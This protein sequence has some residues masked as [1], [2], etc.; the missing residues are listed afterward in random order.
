MQAHRSRDV[1]VSLICSSFGRFLGWNESNGLEGY[2]G[3]YYKLFVWRVAR[4]FIRL[5]TS[6]KHVI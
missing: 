1:R 4:S 2:M 5:Y 6:I 3:S